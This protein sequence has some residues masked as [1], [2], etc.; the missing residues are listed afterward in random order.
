MGE[1]NSDV[2]Y[3]VGKTALEKWSSS[4]SQKKSPKCSIQVQSQK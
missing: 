3:T 2:H 1:F 4:Y